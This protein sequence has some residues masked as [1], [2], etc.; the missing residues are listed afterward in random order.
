[1]N[2]LIAAVELAIDG[3]KPVCGFFVSSPKPNFM[4]NSALER[5]GFN[6][7]IQKL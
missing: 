5:T 7:P 3:R 4:D 1:M 2:Q 6:I